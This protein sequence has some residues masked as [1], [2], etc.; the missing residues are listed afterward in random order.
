M[1]GK[2]RHQLHNVWQIRNH[3]LNS[4]MGNRA[5]LHWLGWHIASR[6]SVGP[7]AAP[8]IDDQVL[9]VAPGMTSATGNIYWG[10]SEP[11]DM[12]F[13]LHF[14]RKHDLFVD[15]GSNVGVFTVIASGAAGADTVAIEAHP[16]TFKDLRRNILVNDLLERVELHNLAVGQ[17]AGSL[18]F[19]SALGTTNHILADDESAHSVIVPMQT[20][21]QIVSDRSPKLLK[22]DV[23]GY[24]LP[25]LRGAPRT[26][27]NRLRFAP[28]SSR[29]MTH[30][31][32]MVSRSKRREAILAE[33]GF[34]MTA[35]D[36]YRR[37]L[38][39]VT[40][41]TRKDNTIFVRDITEAQRIVSSAPAYQLAGRRGKI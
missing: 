35:Y 9:V 37:I 19:S 2:L 6:L 22:I 15:V 34:T 27:A 30:P 41:L 39:P 32:A 21:D 1:I 33:A 31:C 26:L 14:L 20:L 28:S 16:G 12:G 3:P 4:G 18:R 25:V 24:E 10:L 36:P 40:G 8:F 7:I 5:V 13:A 23:E 11:E 17:D 38:T 29:S